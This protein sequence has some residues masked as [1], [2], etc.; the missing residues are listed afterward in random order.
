M[1]ARTPAAALVLGLALRLGAGEAAAQAAVCSNT[2]AANQRIDCREGSSSMDDIRIDARNVAISVT[3][4][5]IRGVY[6]KHDGSGDIDVDLTGGSVTTSGTHSYGVGVGQFGASGAIDIGLKDVVVKTSG[7]NAWGVV[8]D[9][10]TGTGAINIDVRGGSIEVAGP[11]SI[12]IHALQRSSGNV[13]IDVTDTVIKA[14]STS[15]GIYALRSGAAGNIDINVRGGSIETNTFTTHGI[16]ARAQ[17]TDADDEGGDITVTVEDASVTNKGSFSYGVFAEHLGK[18]GITVDVSGGSVITS[19]GRNG[20]GVYAHHG[21]R[22]EVTGTDTTVDMTIGPGTLV[23]SPFGNGVYGQLSFDN[24]AGVAV[25]HAGAIEARDSGIL[26]WAS[27][28]SG[29]VRGDGSVLQLE[30]HTGKRQPM[31]HVVSSGDIR[32]G[33]DVADAYIREV[34]TGADGTLSVAERAVLDAIL[35]E[36]STALNTALAALPAAYTDPWKLR[37]RDFLSARGL[38]TTDIAASIIPGSVGRPANA[39]IAG[40]VAAREILGIPRAGIRAMAISHQRIAEYIQW[41]DPADT[42]P[43]LSAAERRVLEAVLTGGDLEAALAALPASYAD[44]YKTGI[45]LRATFF[46]EGDIRVDVTGGTIISDGDGVYARYVLTNDRNGAISVNVA[47]G[48]SV[49]GER[50]GIYVG[51]AGLAEGNDDLRAQSVTVNG[52][53]TGGTGSGIHMAGGGRLTV[54]ASGHVGATSG[55][56]VLADG[57]G[58]LHATVAG[59]VE[60]DIRMTGTGALTLALPEGGVI[61]GTIRDPVGLSTVVGSIG[62]LLYSNAPTTVT[63]ASTGALTGVEVEGRTE[64]LRS[65]A[66]DLNVRVAG[67]V[68]GDIR[69]LGDGDLSATVTGTVDG[70]VEGL[71]GGDHTVAVPDGGTVTGTVNLAGSTVTV[72]GTVGRI[73]LATGGTVRI[74]STGQVTGVSAGSH[75]VR[76]GLGSTIEN[77]G[78]IAGTTGIQTGARSTIENH[79]TIT[80]TIGIQAGAD[81]TIENHGTIAGTTGIQ[82]GARSTVVNAGPVRS[83]AGR[84]GKAIHISPGANTLILQPGFEIIGT[85]QGVSGADDTPP[86]L[87]EFTTGEVGSLIFL[88]DTGIPKFPEN[89]MLPSQRGVGRMLRVG[90]GVLGMDT[91]VFALTDDMLS[92]LTGSIHAAVIGNGLQA[93]AGDGDPGRAH[94]WAAPF[95]G[96]REQNGAGWL[97]DSTHYFGG[98]MLGAGWGTVTRVGLFVG[99]SVGQLDVRA[100]TVTRRTIDMQTVFGGVY[101]RRDLGDVRLDAR[102]LVGKTD[103][104]STRRARRFSGA[105][106]VEYTS[107]FLSPEVGVATRIQLMSR[108]HATP[109]LRVRYAG[110]F[111]EGFHERA[112]NWDVRF[113]KR[114]VHVLE[115]RGEVGIPLALPEGGRIEPRVGIEGRWLAAGDTLEV[116]ANMGSRV[117]DVGG[118]TSVATGTVGVGMTL[119]VVGSTALVGNFDGAYTTEEAWR[120][121]GYLGLTYSF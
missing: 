114:D 69:A 74:A 31:I 10:M 4:T 13:D 53:V 116:A 96:A 111:T 75:G 32:V 108:L 101:A 92:D 57:A 27:L 38:D 39:F 2:P 82:T 30:D 83:T 78:T 98:G 73:T 20:F 89:L 14:V 86:D 97:A 51:S 110:L 61:T 35:A 8:G 6:G 104:D 3:G 119:P 42:D 93:Q 15:L 105:A 71:G 17:F 81:S 107:I 29:L 62:R 67:T 23:R 22:R 21:K 48:A 102:V 87:S 34:V 120:A 65:D 36:D 9:R 7:T 1:S 19:E 106:D 70:D 118:D 25:S 100:Q 26:A 112:G 79:G 18:G 72:G 12:A 55:V 44:A 49:T 63:V 45:R 33:A 90:A 68:R 40:E 115:A 5:R 11:S 95:G 24:V 80:G 76:V 46:N 59:R 84:A 91:T 16:Y 94:V 52:R 113:A 88:D 66:G 64:A 85:I 99:G 121:T 37:A 56:G 77:H 60:G 41:A 43:N 103:H 54:G 28:A 109:R 50:N 47:D 58:D 117:V